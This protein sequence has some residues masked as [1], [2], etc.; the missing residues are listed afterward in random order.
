V[1]PD[2]AT[3]TVPDVEEAEEGETSVTV[4]RSASPGRARPGETRTVGVFDGPG[5]VGN[6]GATSEAT[7]ATARILK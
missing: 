3:S 4:T 6:A 1:A 5:S 2:T 7:A